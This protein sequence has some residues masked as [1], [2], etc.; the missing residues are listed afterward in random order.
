MKRLRISDDATLPLDFI[1]RRLGIVA[2]TGAGKTYTAAVLM[3]EM[4]KAGLPFAI[5]DPGGVC[6]GLRLSEDGKKPGYPVV[7]LG[8]TH[9]DMPLEPTAGAVLAEFF[10]SN[11]LP[12]V[13]D[14]SDFSKGEQTRFMTDF[15]TTL[16]RLKGRD[17]QPLHLLLDEADEF[18]PQKPYKGQERLLGAI[19]DLVRR[20]RARGIGV[21]LI[22]QRSAVLNKDV[23]T[24]VDALLALRTG[25]PQDR[26]AIEAWIDDHSGNAD[27]RAQV[28]SSLPALDDGIGWLW[29]P[30]W[31]KLLRQIHI[32]KRETFDSSA[33]PTLEKARAY[34]PN[35]A[36]KVDLE[37][38]S[39]RMKATVEKIRADDPKELRKQIARLTEELAAAR[40]VKP[41]EKRVEV[42]VLSSD[43][44]H[45][46]EQAADAL[47]RL[48]TRLDAH[49]AGIRDELA[50][51]KRPVPATPVQPAAPAA[52]RKSEAR[53]VM[54]S[55]SPARKGANR[56][57]NTL[58]RFGRPLT[59]NQLALQ[60]CFS[61]GSGTYSTYL[62]RLRQSGQITDDGGLIRAVAPMDQVAAWP[63]DR[64]LDEWAGLLDGGP[65]RL[66]DTLRAC[67]PDALHR[68]MLAEQAG[69]STASGT[70]STYLSR[71]RTRGLIEDARNGIRL[72]ADLYLEG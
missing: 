9:G 16:Y 40:S 47:S 36:A 53:A 4:A 71:L 63:A 6:W 2:Q 46:L 57:L 35:K 10:V 18:A 8:G 5:A 38:L 20:G 48:A 52:V 43:K 33:T 61:P 23:L 1:T 21:T 22:T 69:F 51:L 68:D 66:F 65:R 3:E 28:L 41:E 72:S 37:K 12:L 25:G 17:R 7:I 50:A 49:A 60:S 45:R 54:E 24:Q 30:H 34:D 29:S 15:A 13:L 14:L 62:S 11:R 32:R 27:E 31:L 59:R 44:V 64:I 39:V 56:L 42:P 58:A 19:Q 70:Y 55:M 67:Y 26:K